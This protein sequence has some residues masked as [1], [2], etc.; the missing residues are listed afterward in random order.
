MLYLWGFFMTKYE[1]LMN[2][3]EKCLECARSTEGVMQ[4]IWLAHANG[5]E[6]EAKSLSVLEAAEVM[7]GAE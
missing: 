1:N 7:E 2:K 4:S 3:A 5:L 6:Q